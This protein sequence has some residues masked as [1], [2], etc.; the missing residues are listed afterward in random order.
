V[1]YQLYVR[2]TAE[3]EYVQTI[4]EYGKL[5]KGEGMDCVNASLNRM[6]SCNRGQS[7]KSFENKKFPGS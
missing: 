3:A 5:K 1:K 2:K 7:F 6:K 4:D